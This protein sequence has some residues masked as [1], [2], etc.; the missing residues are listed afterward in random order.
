MKNNYNFQ[1][2]IDLSAPFFI[3]FLIF[4]FGNIY[5]KSRN[6]LIPI[7]AYIFTLILIVTGMIYLWLHPVVDIVDDGIIVTRLLL[8]KRKIKWT[9]IILKKKIRKITRPRT[10]G[11]DPRYLD[12]I[13]KDGIWADKHIYIMPFFKDYDSFVYEIEK[14]LDKNDIYKDSDYI[15]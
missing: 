5:A 4:I 10:L 2:K 3:A 15:D 14:H 11:M 12:I 6:I 1:G 9:N 8:N 7:E 13:I